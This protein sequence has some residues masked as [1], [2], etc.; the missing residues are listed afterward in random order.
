MLPPRRPPL[1]LHPHLEGQPPAVLAA[2]ARHLAGRDAGASRRPRAFW[3]SLRRVGADDARG[4]AVPW[5]AAPGT[6]SAWSAKS[7]VETVEK[8]RKAAEDTV[9][10]NEELYNNALLI[11]EM[12]QATST[13]LDIRQLAAAVMAILQKRLD[14]DRG[15]L[16]LADPRA[17]PAQVR[18]RLRPHPGAGSPPA[19]TTF[20]LEQ[21]RLAR[22]VHPGH[23]RAPALPGQRHPLDRA[24]PLGQEPRVRSP[25]RRARAHL[26]AGGVREGAARDPRGRQQHLQRGRCSRAT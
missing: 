18:R 17:E 12:G 19:Q 21:P 20:N 3:L 22:G 7:L 4:A 16:M 9:L 8:Q 2:D 26:R 6:A 5:S 11:L 10:R 23:A 1:P 24:G 14:F 15:M 25:A 13:I